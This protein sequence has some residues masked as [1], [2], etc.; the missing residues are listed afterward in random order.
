MK[1]EMC[2]NSKF[3]KISKLS[4][5]MMEDILQAP[6]LPIALRL[7]DEPRGGVMGGGILKDHPVQLPLEDNPLMEDMSPDDVQTH[8]VEEMKRNFRNS[9]EK[10]KRKHPKVPQEIWDNYLK[11]ALEIF[12]RTLEA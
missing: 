12:D 2:S 5:T 3:A 1:C 6:D 4:E 7:P 11:A 8:N 9:T 10:L